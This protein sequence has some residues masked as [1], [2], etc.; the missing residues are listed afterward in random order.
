M[1]ILFHIFSVT[2]KTKIFIKLEN[3]GEGNLD[4][5]YNHLFVVNKYIFNTVVNSY[6]LIFQL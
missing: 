3:N 2:N 6:A 5:F 4:Q 1:I